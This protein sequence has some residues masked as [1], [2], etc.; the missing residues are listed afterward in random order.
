VTRD[1]P[2]LQCRRKNVP[3]APEPCRR[4]EWCFMVRTRRGSNRIQ[5]CGAMLR[6]QGGLP[7]DRQCSNAALRP[8]GR[9]QPHKNRYV[10]EDKAMPRGCK[11]EGEHALSNAERQARHRARQQMPMPV[12]RYRRPPIGAAVRNAGAMPAANWSPCKPNTLHGSTRFP[13]AFAPRQQERRCRPS[14]TSTSTP[15]RPSIRPVAMDAID[16]RRRQEKPLDRKSP[17]QG[18]TA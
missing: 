10:T 4:S 8:P 3:A 11:P 12:I 9:G 15:W 16:S 5:G 18:P 6:A 17:I 7:S 13:T 2:W 1:G 14:R